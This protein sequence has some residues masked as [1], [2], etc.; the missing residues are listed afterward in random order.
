[1][2]SSAILF[3]SD[4]EVVFHSPCLIDN[5]SM[6]CLQ[7][8]RIIKLSNNP[9]IHKYPSSWIIVNCIRRHCREL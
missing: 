4:I 6:L 3:T 8:H 1:M 9:V 7:L 2:V 5:L